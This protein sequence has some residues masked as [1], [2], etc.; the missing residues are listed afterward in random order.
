MFDFIFVFS[1]HKLDVKKKK[2]NEAA[3]YSF[4]DFGTIP[5]VLHI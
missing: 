3:K 5:L 4:K 2:N 1:V